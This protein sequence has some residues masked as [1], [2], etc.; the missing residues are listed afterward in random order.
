VRIVLA[1]W[2]VH[3]WVGEDGIRDPERVFEHLRR[4]DADIVALQEVDGLDWQGRADAAGYR[5]I[6]GPTRSTTFGN[7]LLLRPPV[8]ASRR[9]D[10]SISGRE[11]RGA[12]DAVVELTAGP[13]RVMATHL[14]L[15]AFERRRQA[16]QL[17]RQ[18]RNRDAW[19]PVVLLGD[20]NDW[21]PSGRQLGPLTHA[22]GPFS[23]LPTFPSRRPVLPLDRVACRTPGIEPAVSVMAWRGVASVSDHLPL[24]LELDAPRTPSR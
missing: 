19:L 20:L 9:L 4:F 17:A 3:A 7:A 11:P 16:D 5:S 1:S 8:L 12:L 24:R 13:L 6:W 21:T 23:R 22:L 18:L 2:N 10:L 15:R 14:G